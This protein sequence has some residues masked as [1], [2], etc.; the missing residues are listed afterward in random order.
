VPSRAKPRCRPIGAA[1]LSAL[2]PARASVTDGLIGAELG[3]L[4]EAD[5]E[6]RIGRVERAVRRALIANNGQP[7]LTIHFLEYAYPRVDRYQHWHYKS[8]YVAAKKFAVNVAGPGRAI[9]IWVPK[10]ELADLISPK[11]D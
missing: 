9:V 5:S 4:G 10:P 2:P 7:L 8:V 11:H 3:N 6:S 1:V